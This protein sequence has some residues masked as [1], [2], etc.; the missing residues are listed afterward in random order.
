MQS[1]YIFVHALGDSRVWPWHMIDITQDAELWSS[2][3]DFKNRLKEIEA[4]YAKE[5]AGCLLGNSNWLD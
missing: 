4:I 5:Y 1:E 2:A 3:R